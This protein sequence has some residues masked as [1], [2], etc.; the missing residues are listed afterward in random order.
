M[1]IRIC[2]KLYSLLVAVFFPFRYNNVT[3]FFSKSLFRTINV[4]PYQ[5]KFAREFPL[6]ISAY[7]RTYSYKL[8][9]FSSQISSNFS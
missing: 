4:N 9:F 2:I 3:N 1:K 6:C 8:S 7:H 5:L